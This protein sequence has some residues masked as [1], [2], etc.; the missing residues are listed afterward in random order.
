MSALIY[1]ARCAIVWQN[2]TLPMTIWQAEQAAQGLLELAITEH[3]EAYSA[4]WVS[5]LAPL[6]NAIRQ[7]KGQAVS[8]PVEEIAA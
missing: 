2:D 3:D 8:R 6:V 4:E 1:T 5:H 7:A